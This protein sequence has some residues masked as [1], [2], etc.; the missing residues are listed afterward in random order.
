MDSTRIFD[1]VLSQLFIV[2]CCW[3]FWLRTLY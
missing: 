3:L 1:L 2:K